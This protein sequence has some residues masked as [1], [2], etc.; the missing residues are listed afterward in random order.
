MVINIKSNNSP[1][2][3]LGRSES[4]E[5]LTSNMPWV[6]L[7]ILAWVSMIALRLV[8]LQVI[9]HHHYSER[10][11][12]Q[13]TVTIPI[14]P[15][16]GDLL[17]RKGDRLAI[18]LKVESLF[19]TPPAFY[20][21]YRMDNNGMTRNF[22]EPER[23]N[24]LKVAKQL[25]PI[26]EMPK[27]VI[28][29]KLLCKKPFVWIKRQLPVE[30]AAA[31]KALKLDGLG[32]LPESKRQYPRG[33]LACQVVGFTS[34]DGVGQLGIERAFNNQLTGQRGELIAPRDAKGKL[35]ILKENFSKTPVH[36][37]SLQ[38]TIDATIQH[39][40]ED[41]LQEGVKRSRPST[42]YAIVVNPFTGE[43]LAM[44]GT[45]VFDPNQIISKK[46]ANRSVDDWSQA[47]KLEYKYEQERQKAARKVHPIEDSY[48]PGSTMKVFTVAIAIENNKAVIG[49]NI[50]CEGG[51]WK[52]H[53]AHITDTH[54]NGNLTLEQALWVSSNIGT[55]KI[56]LRIEPDVHYQYLRKFGFGESTGL[57][58][59]GETPGRLPPCCDWSAT[60]Q[61]TMS[62]GYGLSVSPIQILMASSAIANGGKLMRPYIVQ[63]I[64][65]D[66]GIVVQEFKPQI[67]D[68][69]ISE[70]TAYIMRNALK[71]VITSGTGKLAK[72]DGGIEAFGKTGTARKI[73][74]NK[75]DMKRHYVSFIGFFPADKPK[76]GVLVMLDDPSGN[77]TG[78]DAAA[79]VF[80][81]IGDAIMCYRLSSHT[82]KTDA[83]LKLGIKY[84]P[85]S[86][87][88]GSVVHVEVGK[89]PDLKGLTLK[90]AIHRVLL[91]GGR[92]QLEDLG[93]SNTSV[94][95][96]QDQSPEAG[97]FLEP[98]A[99]VKI[100]LRAS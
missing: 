68:Q 90:S 26:I 18:S 28:L 56:G 85:I 94:V 35:L 64:F 82:N 5:S 1:K 20:P 45:P 9:G 88:D 95:R 2:S 100:K 17:D 55:A 60:S 80:K 86:E 53:N 59:P 81:K 8:W 34:I 74:D 79:P 83:D 14:E 93:S 51:R 23:E 43:I 77:A 62:Y 46:F 25:E 96:V 58:F 47:D 52:Y 21:D 76:Y 22:G 89:V 27:H 63:K 12:H 91:A 29:E 19:C 73:I 39:I 16:R 71:G 3:L 61:L 97:T 98:K 11:R 33:S 87:N 72:L 6:L 4:Y 54:H 99:V 70:K 40:V 37:V 78:G 36:G 92:P 49:E 75:Y 10:A 44:A 66:K 41:A 48:E 31:I 38:L 69:V 30:K 13:H 7:G 65:N 24:A 67:K 32:F 42:A 84:W 57:N 15:T 50:N